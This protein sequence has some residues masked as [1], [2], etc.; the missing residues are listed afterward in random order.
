MRVLGTISLLIGV[1]IF[2]WPWLKRLV[3]ELPTLPGDRFFLAGLC[4]IAGAAL[5]L[6]ASRTE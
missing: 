4:L 1:T 3:D 6:V 2:S 5:F